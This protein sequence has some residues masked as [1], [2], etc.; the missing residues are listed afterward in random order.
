[1]KLVKINKEDR[2]E[3]FSF[4]SIKNKIYSNLL[5]E[6]EEDR[7]EQ[8]LTEENNN[9]KILDKDKII[10]FF[11][12]FFIPILGKN[13]VELKIR[14]NEKEMIKLMEEIKKIVKDINPA[15]DKFF[16]L[17]EGDNLKIKNFISSHYY[18]NRKLNLNN[19]NYYEFAIFLRDYTYSV[20]SDYLS[21]KEID[22]IFF[23]RG[24]W[25]KFSSKDDKNIDFLYVDGKHTYSKEIY[26]K[27]KKVLLKN[28]ISDHKNITRKDQLYTN[29]EPLLGVKKYLLENYKVDLNNPDLDKIKSL[30]KTGK[31]FW[32]KN[33]IYY[34]I[35]FTVYQINIEITSLKSF[36]TYFAIYFNHFDFIFF[37]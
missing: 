17:I 30:F 9:F 4:L 27:Y 21:D 22:D 12:Y 5:K 14:G 8:M 34:S 6:L 2:E 11:S 25:R 20:H 24:N 16:F 18:F 13:Y 23:K 19:T 26:S 29:L 31:A 35:K 15:K 1:M 37:S 33:C 10:G 3:L 32:R 36:I 7:V 28:Q